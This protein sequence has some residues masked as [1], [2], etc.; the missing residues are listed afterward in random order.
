[1]QTRYKNILEQLAPYH[2]QLV[3]V[4]KTQPPDAV[5]ELYALGQRKF[6]ENKVQE[7]IPKQEQLPKDIEWHVIGHLQ[8]NKVKYIAPFV[9]MIES[10]DSLE[11]LQEINRQGMKCDRVIPCLLQ[12][13]IAQESSKFGLSPEDAERMLRSEAFRSMQHVR[14]AGVM[15]MASFTEDLSQVRSEFRLLKGIFE[16]LK[17]TFFAGEPG[18]CEIS[19]GMSSDYPIALEEGAT[20]VRIGTLL[21]GERRQKEQITG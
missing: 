16:H 10:V 19:M 20:L 7:L 14:I 13:H 2:A 21:F 5:V 11:L 17:A 8:R 3:A 6:G 1:M 15:G 12:F 4:S 18:F 9:A